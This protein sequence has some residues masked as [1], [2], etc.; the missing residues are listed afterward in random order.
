VDGVTNTR[1]DYWEAN[2]LSLHTYAWSVTSFGGAQYSGPAKRGED[3]LIPFRKG[4]RSQRK[5]REA[6]PYD[7]GM[8]VV[9][10]S[11]D[12]GPCVAGLTP[13]QMADRNFRTV[14]E[15]VDVDGL[16]PFVKRWW[17]GTTLMTATALA[18][19][20]DSNGPSTSDGDSF[21]YTIN[22]FLADPYFYAPPEVLGTGPVLIKGD[23]ATS[24]F[25][26]TFTL[27]TN[28]RLTLPDGNW[29]QYQGSPGMTP[30]V[31]D[32][33]TGLAM[34]GSSYVN[35]LIVRNP[36]FPDWPV[37][38]PGDQTITLSGGGAISI[39]YEAAYR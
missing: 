4:R 35:G 36:D 13:E 11:E 32:V 5:S 34:H 24:R 12:G 37:L 28:P 26:V 20:L 15:A 6:K 30:V 10:R 14:V 22:L 39:E 7:L 19:Y 27:G 25:T 18:E 29:I 8:V 38:P 9:P 33:H 1:P 3:L 17:D 21:D 2:G 31:I 23:V 16:F